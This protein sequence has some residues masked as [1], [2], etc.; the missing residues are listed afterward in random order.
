MQMED[1]L[2]YLGKENTTSNGR[3]QQLFRQMEVVFEKFAVGL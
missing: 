2:I 3:Q 1:D